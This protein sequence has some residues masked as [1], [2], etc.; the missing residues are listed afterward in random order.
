[1]ERLAADVHR[2]PL[3][4]RDAVN[5]YL[6]GDV[7]VDSGYASSA[8]RLVAAAR[9]HG[10]GVYAHPDHGGSSA[11]VAGA[12]GVPVWAGARD[13]PQVEAGFSL[14]ADTWFATLLSRANS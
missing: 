3:M 7:L 13:A 5:A 14:V 9:E 1:M 6:L 10:V 8:R 12:F 11:A 4:R 2:I